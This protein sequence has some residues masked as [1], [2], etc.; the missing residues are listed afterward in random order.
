M[1]AGA[2]VPGQIVAVHRTADAEG[3]QVGGI[4]LE[5]G[6]QVVWLDVMD[7]EILPAP[8]APADGVPRYVPIADRIPPR[9][10]GRAERFEEAP[11]REQVC[12]RHVQL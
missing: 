1:P 4:Q 10:A 7:L 3:Q 8:T 11:L 5:F 6:E 9:I 12:D 2:A